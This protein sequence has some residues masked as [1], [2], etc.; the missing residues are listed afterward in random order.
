MLKRLA[1]SMG[2]ILFGSFLNMLGNLFLVPLFLG[3]WG[4]TTYGEWMALSAVVAYL[5][6]MDLGMNM[7]AVNEMTMAYAKRDLR[8]YRSVQSSATAFYTLVSFVVLTAA[9]VTC[10]FVPFPIWL[11]IRSI[12]AHIAAFVSWLLAARLMLQLLAIQIWGIYRSIGNLARFEW[13]WNT[14]TL[15]GMAITVLVLF[16]GGD[17]LELAAWGIMPVITVTA[18]IWGIL[19]Y[20]NPQL[21][22]RPSQASLAAVRSLMKPSLSFGLIMLAIALA[23]H[24]PVLLVSA[25]LGGAAV[26]LLVSTRTLANVAGNFIG[27][28]TGAVWPEVTRLHAIGAEAQL[29]IGNRCLSAASVVSSAAI[30]GAL[31]FN[32]AS[33]IRT[34]TSG[35]LEPDV[36]L[37]RL[38]LIALLLQAPWVA[39]SLIS[40]ATN[41]NRRLSFL[42]AG[43]AILTVVAT[44]ILLPHIGIRAVPI[45]MILGEA[46][47]CYHFVL[48]DTCRIVGDSYWPF[49]GRVWATTALSFCAAT[50]AAWIIQH[51]TVGPEPLRWFETG[52]FTMI[53]CAVIGW[54]IALR[55]QERIWLAGRLQLA[56]CGHSA[57]AEKCI[58]S[59]H[60]LAREESNLDGGSA[61]KHADPAA[62]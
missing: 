61:T 48:K 56:W 3:R 58:S 20:S 28:L 43:S 40:T 1:S 51:V 8:Q 22:P 25:S 52:T 14:V 15:A 24:A 29:R 34:W 50:V 18:I 38:F 55:S 44:S 46:A 6:T 12:P 47:A 17:A 31:W 59:A 26:A 49:A 10:I 21:L 39:S 32:G 19:H 36:V 2:A 42:R 27:M 62:S 4:K 7:A 16:T 37:L 41:R 30:A 45:A 60:P 35:K 13:I 5:S 33:V 23:F 54:F 9:A 57:T 11:G 53:V